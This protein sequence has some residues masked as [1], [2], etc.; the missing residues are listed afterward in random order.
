MKHAERNIAVFL[1]L[2]LLIV[3]LGFWPTYFSVLGTARLSIHTH[4]V[5]M[6]LWIVMLMSQ[7]WLALTGRMTWHRRIGRSSYLIAPLMLWLGIVVSHESI[8]RGVGTVTPDELRLLTF[9]LGGL[10]SFSV[11][12]LLAIS[13]RRQRKLHSRFMIASGLAIMGGAIIR[14][15]LFW[16]PG[17][18]S[19]GVAGNVNFITL[20][21]V[22]GMLLWRDWRSDGPR[23][24][25]DSWLWW[26]AFAEAFYHWPNL[27][28]WAPPG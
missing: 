25:A 3:L 14:V 1:A 20:E 17:L 21:F 28:P 26:E 16:V 22:T 13:Y 7:A 9:P 12:Y 6:I 8:Q 23:D 11:T 19:L 10:L 18:G 5:L 4:S 24:L 2:T 27:A 15:Y